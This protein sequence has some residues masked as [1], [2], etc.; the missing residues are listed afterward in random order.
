MAMES[1]YKLII[2][3]HKRIFILLYSCS[4]AMKSSFKKIE[5]G[6]T[7]QKGH[8]GHPDLD[9]IFAN[10]LSKGHLMILEEDHPTTNYLSLLRYFVGAGYHAGTPTLIYDANPQKWRHLIPPVRKGADRQPQG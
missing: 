8:F 5:K 10:S 9:A 6:S 1:A 7:S 4:S 2:D 3:N